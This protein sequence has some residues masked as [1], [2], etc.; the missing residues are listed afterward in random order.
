MNIR[1]PSTT[2]WAS[3]S[4]LSAILILLNS[5]VGVVEATAPVRVVLYDLEAR[6]PHGEVSCHLANSLLKQFKITLALRD[7]ATNSRYTFYM[8]WNGVPNGGSANLGDLVTNR[9]GDLNFHVHQ[10]LDSGNYIVYFHLDQDGTM[11][12]TTNWLSFTI[13]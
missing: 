12:Y 9:N 6:L 13:P 3:V 4:A 11:Q 2:R 5:C 7:A 8:E 10:Y 1:C